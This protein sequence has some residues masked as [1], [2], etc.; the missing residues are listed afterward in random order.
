MLS[1]VDIS[2]K[3]KSIVEKIR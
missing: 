1:E 2:K 3:K